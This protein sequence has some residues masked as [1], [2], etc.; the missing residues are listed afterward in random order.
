MAANIA[1]LSPIP[2]LFLLS[3]PPE[4]M[5]RPKAHR[6]FTL[7]ELI[8]VIAIIAIIVA[9]VFVAMDPVKRLNASRNSRR[10]TDA[11]AIAQAIN[12]STADAGLEGGEAPVTLTGSVTPGN[13]GPWYSIVGQENDTCPGGAVADVTPDAEQ[14]YLGGLISGY[15]PSVPTDPDSD[16]VSTNPSYLIR[17]YNGAVEVMVCNPESEAAGGSGEHEGISISR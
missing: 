12:L 10:R 9:A 7:I 2:P 1:L 11:V 4:H 3:L 13:P 8:I 15:L 17:S 14:I 5:V 16:F 6:G